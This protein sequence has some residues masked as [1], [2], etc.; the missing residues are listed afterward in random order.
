MGD[1]IGIV[2]SVD[3]FLD[4]PTSQNLL[5]VAFDSVMLTVGSGGQIATGLIE[6]IYKNKDGES[7]LDIAL[8][9]AA[10]KIDRSIDC[11]LGKGVHGKIF[12]N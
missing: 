5:K 8:H 10:D 6:A 9:F 7:L 1:A 4:E 3:E 12:R 2:L 11:N